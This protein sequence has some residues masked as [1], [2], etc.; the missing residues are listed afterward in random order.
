MPNDQVAMSPGHGWAVR[1][2]A[3]LI[4]V[5]GVLAPQVPL[6]RVSRGHVRA[7]LLR[8]DCGLRGKPHPNIPGKGRGGRAGGPFTL[9]PFD[10]LPPHG[11]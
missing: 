2:T 7:A 5:E 9:F 11:L 4:M 8:Q 3:H 6:H 1:G 10:S